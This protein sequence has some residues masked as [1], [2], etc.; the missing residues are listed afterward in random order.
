MDLRAV[1]GSF[2]RQAAQGLKTQSPVTDY[3]ARYVGAL[4]ERALSQW[5]AVHTSG[6]TC[7]LELQGQQGERARCGGP[8]IGGCMV[9][10]A[11]V[12]IGHA[13]VSP[14]HIMC[15]GCAYAAREM[16]ATAPVRPQQPFSGGRPPWETGRDPFGGGVPV[17][18]KRRECL[19]VLDLDEGA[20]D[21]EI[22]RR[23][24]KL[25]KQ[26]HP[27]HAPTER[28]RQAAQARMAELNEA[29]AYLTKRR[30]A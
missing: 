7:G 4:A 15:L 17:D 27:D 24:R 12:C 2:A 28:T 19:S 10:G 14:E 21:E 9:C 13:L 22:R 23:Y 20:T 3:Y 8:A 18:E 25:A 1:I 26:N 29:Y 30:A 5:A 11:S 6:V 16:S